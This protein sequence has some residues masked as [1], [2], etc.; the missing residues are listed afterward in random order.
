MNFL[1]DGYGFEDWKSQASRYHNLRAL[2]FQPQA[3][4]DI[5]AY[6][7]HWG[8]LA[9]HI[10]P[11]AQILCIEANEDCRPNLTERGF[12]FEIALLDAVEREADYYKCT[13]GCGEGNG[14]FKENSIHPFVATKQRTKTLDSI[15]GDR[16]FD[17]IKL[18]CQGG[19]LSVLSGGAKAVAAAHLVQLEVQVQDYNESA[20]RIDQVIEKMGNLGFRVY[21]IIDF[22]YNSRGML[23]QVDLL[24]AKNDS[25][26]FNVRPLS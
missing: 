8:R 2:G 21:D 15:V 10:W 7:A 3:I 11:N 9:S 22:H 12:P 1:P 6:H 23:L 17:F 14:L 13:T 16:I 18:D 24:F 19:E 26:L 25:P 20:P 5:G 4:L